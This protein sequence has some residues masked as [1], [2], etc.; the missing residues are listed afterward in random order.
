MDSNRIANDVTLRDGRSVHIRTIHP[1]DEA[2]LLQ[3]FDRLSP[4]A[5]YMRFMR[6][7]NE[8]DLERL[9][10]AL[11]ASFPERRDG[12]VA[13]IPAIDGIDIV[14]AA[15]FV[16]GGDAS[17]CEFAINVAA[18]FGGAGLGGTL[19]RTLIDAAR[20]RGLKVMEGFVLADNKSMLGLARRLG[21]SVTRDPDDGGIRL[22]RLVSPMSGPRRPERA[23]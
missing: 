11:L 1:S 13:T 18:E 23:P 16:F 22:C 14:G 6:F 12:V 2:E 10:K 7:V 17:N 20:Q 5:R 8:P 19:M 3:A 21:F 9:R 4:T 15:F